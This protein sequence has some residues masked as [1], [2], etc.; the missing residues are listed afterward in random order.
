MSATPIQAALRQLDAECLRAYGDPLF[1]EQVECLLDSTRASEAHA[2][3]DDLEAR[4]S[5]NVG[6][7]R[8]ALLA[9]DSTT[10][11]LS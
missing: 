8:I 1:P 11:P 2:M 3:L 7:M 4:C 5:L 10:E 9:R 6:P